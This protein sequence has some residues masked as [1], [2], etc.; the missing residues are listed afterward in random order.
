M[1]VFYCHCFYVSPI[2][3]LSVLLSIRTV[4]SELNVM[5]L[6]MMITFRLYLRKE[7]ALYIEYRSETVFQNDT[8]SM[9]CSGLELYSIDQS[10]ILDLILMLNL[11]EFWYKSSISKSINKGKVVITNKC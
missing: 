7:H 5:L 2:S 8:S 10:L 3:C 11:S 4:V 6:L 1:R 9:F